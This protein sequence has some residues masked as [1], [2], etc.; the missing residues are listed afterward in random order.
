MKI[1]ILL[2]VLFLPVIS[3]A[4][5]PVKITVDE[6]GF[7][8]RWYPAQNVDAATLIMLGGSG[9]GHTFGSQMAPWF[10]EH[11]YHVL[12]V[13]YFGSES[14]P[15]HLEEIPLEFLDKAIV[16]LD[17]QN[18]NSTNRFSLL[19]VSKGA[20]LALVQASRI[21]RFNA[22]VA[23]SPSSVVWQSI[24]QQNYLSVKSS[25][26]LDG[27]PV[28]FVPYCYDRGYISIFDFYDCALDK[29]MEDDAF[30]KV[31]RMNAPVLLLSGGDDKLWP[32]ERMALM[33]VERFA[34]HSYPHT[35]YQINYPKA[36]HWLLAPYLESNTE[37]PQL[38][39]QRTFDFL[40][41]SAADLP[42]ISAKTESEILGFL[43]KY[44]SQK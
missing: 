18:G 12:S 36:G 34:S 17:K 44:S 28:P 33:L 21:D 15:E 39:D 2:L 11:G 24:N 19:G 30:I 5:T 35:V 25:W 16:W 41:G 9:G 42:E 14:L 4:S 10:N 7:D 29:P 40:G 1:L 6:H 8:G 23:I 43:E 31:E 27:E 20:E 37:D 32:A 22:I 3:A 38:Q 13:A 26:T